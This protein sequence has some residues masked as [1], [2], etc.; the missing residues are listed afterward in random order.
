MADATHVRDTQDVDSDESYCPYQCSSVCRPVPRPS[1]ILL[2]GRSL[3]AQRR[4]RF[5]AGS[6]AHPA[7]LGP[8]LAA[9]LIADYTAPGDW[10]FDPLAGTGTTL[11]EAVRSGRHAVGMEYEPGWVALARAN[12]ALARSHGAS[13]HGRLLRADATGLPHGV[14]GWVRGQIALILTTPPYGTIMNTGAPHR[15]GS[16]HGVEQTPSSG[17]HVRRGRLRLLDAITAVLT[18]CLPLL[19]PGG[20]VAVVSRPRRRDGRLIEPSSQIVTAGQHAGLTLVDCRRAVHTTR[21]RCRVP[22]QSGS[23]TDVGGGRRMETSLIQHDDIAV[24]QDLHSGDPR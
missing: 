21:D 2:G 17:K 8:D 19:R 18:G 1:V 5:V 12:L 23:A 22:R 14:P 3:A 9:H 15:A 13:G 6:G 7:R 4:G 24:F 11:V 16:R 20:V 10:V